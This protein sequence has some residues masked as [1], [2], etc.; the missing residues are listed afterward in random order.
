MASKLMEVLELLDDGRPHGLEELRRG[1][2]LNEQQIN[3]VADF[4]IKYGFAKVNPESK[5]IMLDKSFEQLM[6]QTK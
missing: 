4:L 5:K 3:E 6:A 1:T 2:K